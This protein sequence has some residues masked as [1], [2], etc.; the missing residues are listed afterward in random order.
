MRVI[1]CVASALV[2]LIA[3]TALPGCG[4]GGGGGVVTPSRTPVRS[5]VSQRG[6]QLDV[7]EFLMTDISITGS[8]G[9]ATVDATVEWTFAT[10][11]VDLYVTNTSCTVEML[12]L[13]GCAYVARANSA[14]AKPERVSFS[15]SAATSYRFWILNFGPTRESGTF[16]VAMTQ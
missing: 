15:V 7:L 13:D 2:C 4:G 5:V 3:A 11:D 14:T 10:N 6:W 16:E 12:I 8:G 9:T 1:K